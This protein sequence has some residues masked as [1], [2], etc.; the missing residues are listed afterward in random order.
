M[1]QIIDRIIEQKASELSRTMRAAKDAAWVA[2][3]DR[4]IAQIDRELAAMERKRK[5]KKWYQ[6]WL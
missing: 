5:A 3:G 1:S 6:F 4:Q 2:E